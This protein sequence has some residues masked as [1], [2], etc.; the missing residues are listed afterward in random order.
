MKSKLF[1]FRTL[2]VSTAMS[3]M[4]AMEAN[5]VVV[6]D[7]APYAG[8]GPGY[9]AGLSRF[10]STYQGQCYFGIVLGRV[11]GTID[12]GNGQDHFQT[13]IEDSEGRLL[14]TSSARPGPT[15]PG[16]VAYRTQP[17][18]NTANNRYAIGGWS[19]DTNE[20]SLPLTVKVRESD[21]LQAYDVVRTLTITRSDFAAIDS[22]C[23][24]QNTAPIANAGED[25]LYGIPNLTVY[26]NG[27]ESS[28]ADGDAL[29]YMWTQILGP[30]VE[31]IDAESASPSF[32]YP[33]GRANQRLEFEL[34]VHDG[35]EW[36][37]PDRVIVI[38]NGRSNGTANGRK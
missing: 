16:T 2:L 36:S 11:R 34:K 10:A 12:D 18:Q 6:D 21:T 31:L 1:N 13:T 9:E 23:F 32:I 29:T 30:I 3:A 15:N 5:A 8:R 25:I 14:S 20:N 27:G 28:D 4:I 19:F 37:E 33:P 24:P 38:H 26:L 7:Y 35:T 17:V 22:K